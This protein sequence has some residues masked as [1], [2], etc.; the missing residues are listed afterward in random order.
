MLAVIG[1]EYLVRRR[2]DVV[3]THLTLRESVNTTKAGYLDV[4]KINEAGNLSPILQQLPRHTLA[5]IR[6]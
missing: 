1:Q 3:G 5:A 2:R 6:R 4:L